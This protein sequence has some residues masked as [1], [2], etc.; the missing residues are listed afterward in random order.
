MN[1]GPVRNLANVAECTLPRLTLLQLLTTIY[2]AYQLTKVSA[3]RLRAE[4]EWSSPEV[5]S[6]SNRLQVKLFTKGSK[7]KWGNFEPLVNSFTRSPY[8]SSQGQ[9]VA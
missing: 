1:L 6:H 5:E 3:D 7:G 8:E 9:K 4:S 2:L